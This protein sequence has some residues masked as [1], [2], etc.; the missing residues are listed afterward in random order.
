MENENVIRKIDGF[1]VGEEFSFAVSS[2][3]WDI[4][5]FI[6]LLERDRDDRYHEIVP[7]LK[8][9]VNKA[10]QEVEQRVDA[11]EQCLGKLYLHYATPKNS[12]N[13]PSG[14]T[15]IGLGEYGDEAFFPPVESNANAA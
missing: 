13:V 1:T 6:E 4:K 15:I 8:T 11:V 3:F 9:I 7:I 5:T 12:L 14:T 10:D 2:V